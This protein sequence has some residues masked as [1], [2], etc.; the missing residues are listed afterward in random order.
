[1]TWDLTVDYNA[2][3]LDPQGCPTGG[4]V[5]VVSCYDDEPTTGSPTHFAS[6][7]TVEF[8]PACAAAR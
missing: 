8:G 3:T 5:H 7:G 4:S 1:M 6:Q 2:I